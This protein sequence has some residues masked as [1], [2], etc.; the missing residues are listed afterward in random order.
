MRLNKANRCP[1]SII[2]QAFSWYFDSYQM[3]ACS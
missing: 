3:L 1:P 2:T